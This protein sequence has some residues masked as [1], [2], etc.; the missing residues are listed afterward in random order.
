M[1]NIISSLILVFIIVCFFLLIIKINYKN[2]IYRQAE[3][4]G[5]D[6]I[7][8]FENVDK[9]GDASWRR[10]KRSSFNGLVNKNIF[11]KK[12]YSF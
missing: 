4:N 6:S 7:V 12:T 2:R 11:H 3:F 1:F 10:A 5:E 9:P 8:R